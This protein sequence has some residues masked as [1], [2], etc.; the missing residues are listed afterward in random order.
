M[1]VDN[2]TLD[3]YIS[4]VAGDDQELATALRER[5][6]RNEKAANNFV[7]GFLR[8]QDYTQKT[9]Q[10]STERGRYES[11]QQQYEERLSQAEAEK[12]KIMKDLAEARING[13][14]ASALLRTVKDAYGLTDNDLPGID[15]I[16]ATART[17]RVV[18]STPDLDQRLGSF[19][20]EIM[21]EITS[22]LIPEISGLAIL[23]P[24]WSDIGYEHEKLFG[25]RLTKK[26]QSEILADARKENKSLEAV[27]QDK[28]GV[29]D[30]RLEVRD[31]ENKAKWQREWEDDRSKRDQE[32]ALRGVTE[33]GK[34]YTFADRQSPIFKRSFDPTPNAEGKPN[35]Q[36]AHLSDASRERTSGAERAAAR[37]IERSR[38]GQL[39][40]PL[41]ERQAV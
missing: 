32:A 10:L 17:G 39:G 24:V 33:N 23:G 8:N 9:Q 16:K 4:D 21:K 11:A 2:A 3:R 14:H 13:S 29:P 37:F 20:A 31:N 22:S 7:G 28:Y 5:L 40:K 1:P 15:D 30:K 18:D 36:P 26:E 27:W 41:Q 12:D 35:T 19:K 38:S 34:D 25:S 6:G